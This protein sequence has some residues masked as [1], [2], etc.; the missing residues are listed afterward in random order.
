MVLAGQTPARPPGT[1]TGSGP[2][3]GVGIHLCCALNALGNCV[4]A[5]AIRGLVPG[6]ACRLVRRSIRSQIRPYTRGLAD[7]DVHGRLSQAQLAP[8][9]IP[10]EVGE[11]FWSRCR[12]VPSTMG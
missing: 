3:Q 7:L 12:S 1:R 6:G 11:M 8:A 2:V 9:V 4:H 10:Q 5:A